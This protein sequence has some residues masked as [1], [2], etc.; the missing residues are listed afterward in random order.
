MYAGHLAVR[1]ESEVE[2]ITTRLSEHM[3]PFGKELV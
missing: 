2:A 1:Y 3:S